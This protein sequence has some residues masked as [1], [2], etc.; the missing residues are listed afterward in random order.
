MTAWAVSSW[1]SPCAA[2]SE[3]M[4]ASGHRHRFV[5]RSLARRRVNQT[6]RTRRLRCLC[7]LP[8]AASPGCGEVCAFRDWVRYSRDNEC[9][10]GGFNLT[11]SSGFS[12]PD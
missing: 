12:A 2:A 11:V 5:R 3:R 8:F 6:T 7:P 1:W 10:V 4:L 9:D